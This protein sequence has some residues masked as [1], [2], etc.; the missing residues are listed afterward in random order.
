M[1]KNIPIVK[2][3][4]LKGHRMRFLRS[5]LLASSCLLSSV[6]A[7]TLDDAAAPD[8]DGAQSAELTRTR[9][10]YTMGFEVETHGIKI[11]NDNQNNILIILEIERKWQLTSDTHDDLIDKVNWVNLEC[12]TVDGLNQDEIAKYAQITADVIRKIKSMCDQQS[13]GKWMLN[14]EGARTLWGDLLQWKLS[15]DT[16][17]TFSTKKQTNTDSDVWVPI[18]FDLRPQLTFSLPLRKTVELFLKIFS[19]DANKDTAMPPFLNPNQMPDRNPW[20]TMSLQDIET[21]TRHFMVKQAPYRAKA[22][23]NFLQ[24]G[25]S[26]Y[27][28]ETTVC[29]EADGLFLILCGYVYDVFFQNLMRQQFQETGPKGFIKVISRIP[30][31]QMYRDLSEEQKEKFKTLLHSYFGRD[32][33]L[34]VKPYRRD[35]PLNCY[36]QTTADVAAGEMINENE[37]ITLGTWFKSIITP[38]TRNPSSCSDLLSPPPHAA[39]DYSMGAL[40]AEVI[41]KNH[42]LLENRGYKITQKENGTTIPYEK[43]LDTLCQLIHGESEAFFQLQHTGEVQ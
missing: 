43:Q 11:Q 42:G 24:R 10:V 23:N 9:E 31:D 34:K 35:A 39:T 5:V 36:E 13:D 4:K 26:S 6:S 8:G 37:R 25:I 28:S 32:L 22:H 27:V 29:T 41:P 40:S 21:S 19:T 12:R 15:A 38:F 2:L 20:D 16:G 14:H 33:E 7:A 1:S 30:F 17:I 3:F 18:D